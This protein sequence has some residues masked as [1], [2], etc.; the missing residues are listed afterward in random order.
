MDAVSGPRNPTDNFT[1]ELCFTYIAVTRV[2]NHK[3]PCVDDHA[4]KNTIHE[5]IFGVV[6]A[7]VKHCSKKDKIESQNSG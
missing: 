7:Y 3:T 1:P 6:I 5:P 4:Y 2:V